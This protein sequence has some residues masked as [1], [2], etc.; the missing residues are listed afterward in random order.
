MGLACSAVADPL[1]DAEEQLKA[2]GERCQ[3]SQLALGPV[4]S[5]GTATYILPEE[6][7][8]FLACDRDRRD[9]ALRRYESVND[10]DID[11]GLLVRIIKT[12][13]FQPAF[14]VIELRDAKETR[15]RVFQFRLTVER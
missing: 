3:R 1:G 7:L 15:L 2:I 6:V 4:Y 13:T 8:R 14:T 9:D 12:L 11:R 10:P 5:A